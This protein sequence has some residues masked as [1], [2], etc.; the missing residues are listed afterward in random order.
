MTRG[1]I[2]HPC[3]ECPKHHITSHVDGIGSL[4]K[5]FLHDLVMLLTA[6]KENT[7]LG[8]EAARWD[9][10]GMRKCRHA[11]N[12]MECPCKDYYKNKSSKSV[13]STDNFTFEKEA[14]LWFSW[15]LSSSMRL[16]CCTMASIAKQSHIANC[17]TKQMKK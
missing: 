11:L 9:M 3:S 15:N 10:D 7:E 8:P 6:P 2:A 1:D 13:S 16:C 14:M 12:I 4:L 17:A 5:A